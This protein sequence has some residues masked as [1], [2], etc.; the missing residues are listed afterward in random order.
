EDLPENM[1]NMLMQ[2][3]EEEKSKAF[4]FDSVDINKRPRLHEYME[5][6]NDTGPM[7][8]TSL[9]KHIKLIEDENP[10]QSN[11]L[12]E[13]KKKYYELGFEEILLISKFP[14]VTSIF[15]W[16]RIDMRPEVETQNGTNRITINSFKYSSDTPGKIPIFVD[17]GQC[18]AIMFR[19][20]PL[21]I[22][23]WLRKNKITVEIDDENKDNARKWILKSMG[24]VSTYGDISRDDIVTQ[25]IYTLVHSVSHIMMKGI[26]GISGFE[27]I[28]LSEYLF[29]DQLSFVI[30]SNKTDFSIGGMHTLFETQLDTLRKRILSQ[31]LV[32]CVHDPYCIQEGGSCLACIQVPEISCDVFNKSLSRKVIYEQAHDNIE[33][34]WKGKVI[35]D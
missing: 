6:I 10:K 30:Y 13:Y 32:T 33:A 35:H 29:P 16:S 14:V 21:K 15:G 27:L 23:N 17:N 8:V 18:E 3:L 24:Q 5:I 19:L 28:G 26:A 22:I 9:T 2:K 31:D 34:F 1:K 25:L 20:D 7:G 11:I 4:D 12:E